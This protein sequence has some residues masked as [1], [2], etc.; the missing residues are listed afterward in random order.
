MI[1]AAK[2]G[3]SWVLR[4]E[5]QK[6]QHSNYPLPAEAATLWRTT[7][8]ETS[9]KAKVPSFKTSSTVVATDLFG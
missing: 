2:N 6:Y 5:H 9:I 8:P 1:T 3:A 7:S 4:S